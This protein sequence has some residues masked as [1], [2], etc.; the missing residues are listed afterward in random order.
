[1]VQ[2]SCCC[3]HVAQMLMLLPSAAGRVCTSVVLSDGG[4]GSLASTLAGRITQDGLR[5][6]GDSCTGVLSSPVLQSWDGL[7]HVCNGASTVYLLSALDLPP[8][9]SDSDLQIFTT[10]VGRVVDCCLECGVESLVFTS[11]SS[12]LS[13]AKQGQGQAEST[14]N[15]AADENMEDAKAHAVAQAEATVLE[16]SGGLRSTSR[17]YTC[18]LR[19]AA[20]I[21]GTSEPQNGLLRRVLS[22]G[23]WG[24]NRFA[25]GPKDAGTVLSSDMVHV[26]N[27]VEAHL[28]AAAKLKTGR[29]K[30]TKTIQKTVEEE[31]QRGSAGGSD[32]AEAAAKADAGP[33]NSGSSSSSSSSASGM[34]A[35]AGPACSGQAYFIGD[36]QPRNPQA[37]LDGILDGLGFATTK[38]VRVPTGVALFAAWVAELACKAGIMASPALTQSDVRSLVESRTTLS[39]ARAKRD[40]GYV[41]SV[42]PATATRKTVDSL[43]RAGWGKHRVSRPSLGYWICNPAGIW[44]VTLAAFGAPCPSFLAPLARDAQ[45]VGISLLHQ[46]SAVR[47]VCVAVYL[48]HA[49]EAVYAFR[50]A[51]KAGHRD[52]APSWSLQTFILGFPSIN[53]VNRLNKTSDGEEEE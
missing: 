52:T 20:V 33:R 24:L 34:A 53:L 51:W 47:A 27:L 26:D 31:E 44:L 8:F 41:P 30:D 16:A 21:Y 38:V 37:F 23:G 4:G 49:L 32:G 9:P 39:N 10:G 13:S 19:P 14:A 46:L 36:G 45:H 12:L 43:R 22:W 42:D 15:I 18:A 29:S 17:L 48:V 11:S 6:A 5:A 1:A 2:Q 35:A 25:V 28:L 7:K 50:T 3:E 40:L